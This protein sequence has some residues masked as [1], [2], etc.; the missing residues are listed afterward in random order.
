VSLAFVFTSWDQNLISALIG[1]FIGAGA[2]FAAIVFQQSRSTNAER[3][4]ALSAFAVEWGHLARMAPDGLKRDNKEVA[5]IPI[6]SD[7]YRFAFPHVAGLSAEARQE[8]VELATVVSAYNTSATFFADNVATR[9][10][11]LPRVREL[12][13]DAITKAGYAMRAL[14]IAEPR[15]NEWVPE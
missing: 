11:V 2:S 7:A 12:G 15:L 14:R 13:E 6:P 3:R 5:F 10:D 1:A 4:A 8:L 9:M